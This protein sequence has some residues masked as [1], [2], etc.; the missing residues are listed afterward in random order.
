[1]INSIVS[2]PVSITGNN[3]IIFADNVSE[4]REHAR[5]RFEA[6]KKLEELKRNE[7]L[8]SPSSNLHFTNTTI[9]SNNNN[10][11]SNS[12]DINDTVDYTNEYD[13]TDILSLA[14]DQMELTKE[15][16]YQIGGAEYRAL[17]LLTYVIPIYYFGLILGSA[18][19]F[20]IYIAVSPFAQQVLLTSNGPENPINPWYM[21]LFIT[22]SAFDNLGISHLDAGLVPFQNAPFPL[23]LLGF[24]I[25]AGNTA[26]PIFLRFILWTMY[27]LTPKSYAMHRETLHYL[28]ENPRRCYTTLFPSRQTWW[29]FAI[30]LMITLTE[31]VVFVVTNYWLPVTDGLSVSTQILDGLFQGI[32]T[33]NAGFSVISL[34]Q[35]NPGTIIVYIVAMYISVYPVAISMR[36]SNVYQERSLGMYRTGED[37]IEDNDE[38]NE[39]GGIIL[40][41][42]RQRTLNSI[43]TASK[44]IIKKPD[45]FVITQIQRQITK[46]ICWVIIGIFL[47]CVLEAQSII[48]PKDITVVTV[49]Y[50]CISAFGN[51]GSSMSNYATSQSAQYRTLSKLI[52][53]ILMYRG[54]HRALP[55]AIDRAVLLPSEQLNRSES[56]QQQL[57]RLHRN[58]ANVNTGFDYIHNSNQPNIRI[59]KRCDTF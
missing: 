9:N 6:K 11:N 17:D 1:M 39:E 4:Q 58:S 27:R 46:D 55:A 38:Y 35:V 34:T 26:Y 41:L 57:Q 25:L 30:L 28:L 49:I 24:L 37:D 44:T 53:I 36:N 15:Q 48:S 29:L 50:E 56:Q 40:K 21:S 45:F 19:A 18:F 54:R 32:A 43:M 31:L 10:N 13:A 22:L 16:R 8:S 47:I 7:K 51:V 59:Y 42:K 20:R 2:S 33:R 52:I 12:I 5:Q 3:N 23:L 14:Q